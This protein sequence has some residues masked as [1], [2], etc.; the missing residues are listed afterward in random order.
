MVN[1][2]FGVFEQLLDFFIMYYESPF[3]LRHEC[4]AEERHKLLE[5]EGYIYRE[6]Y[7]E[8]VPPYQS[9]SKTL[10]EASPALGMSSDF[11]SFAA[12]GLFPAKFRLYEHQL[13]AITANQRGHNVVITAGTGSGKTECFLL[14]VISRLVEESQSWPEPSA[15]PSG[16]RWWKAGDQRVSK[17]AH[18][19]RAAAIRALI[20][21]PMNALVEDQMQR[22]RLALDSPQAR[23]WL[24]INRRG[25]RFYFGRYTGRTP[26]AGRESNSSKRR[27]LR[28]YFLKA[29]ETAQGVA[30]DS[31]RRYFFP[32]VDGGEILARWDMQ[33]VPPDILITNYS[34]LNVMLMRDIEQGMFEI[35]KQWLAEDPS[36]VFTLVVDELHMYRG[37]PGTEVALLLRN[38][39]L[40]LGLTDKPDQVRF[41]A[42]SASLEDND[43]GREYIGQFFGADSESFEIIPGSY[44]LP[45]DGPSRNFQ[46]YI[47]GFKNFRAELQANGPES[48]ARKLANALDV[49]IEGEEDVQ[50]I[51]GHV[52][53]IT[54]CVPAL[55]N[56]SIDTQ[57]HR[58]RARRFSDLAQSLFDSRPGSA[59]A[60]EA[61]AGLLMALA[62]ARVENDESG[63]LQ[64]LLPVRVH[65]FFRNVQGVW[66]CSNPNCN[67]VAAEFQ[68]EDRPVGKLYLE[69]RI[70]CECGARVLDLL[71]CQNC[72][73]VFLGGYKSQDPDNVN[74]WFLFPD[75]PNLQDLPD[76]AQLRKSAAN[77]GLYWPSLRKPA[78]REWKRSGG[79]QQ[80]DFYFSPATLDPA[81]AR[82]RVS[83]VDQTGW[84]FVVRSAKGNEQA[85]EF[86]PP[87]P[88]ICPRCGVD[89]EGN[90][91]LLVTDSDRT[92]SYIRWQ[93]TGFEK[94]NQVLADSL[95][96]QMPSEETRKLVLFSDSR[97]DA[98]KLSAGLEA[99]HYLDALRQSV[100]QVPL[101]S[102]RDV[103]TYIRFEK[104][105]T[106]NSEEQQIAEGFATSYPVDAFAIRQFVAGQANGVQEQR[107]K[108]AIARIGAP[109]SLR[110]IRDAVERQILEMGMNPAGPDPSMQRFRDTGTRRRWTS[111]YELTE[112]EPPRRKQPGELSEDARR[113]L[114]RINDALLDNLQYV[115]FA[116]MRR[117]IESLRLAICTYRRSP[118]LESLCQGLD[119]TLLSEVC[120]AT[121]R[122][123]G[124][125]FRFEGRLS[126]P[127]PPSYLRRYW[128]A[129]AQGAG[130]SSETLGEAV[131]QVLE[132]SGAMREF[133]LQTA[134]VH[135]RT[136]GELVW[137]C[138]QC[139]RIHLHPSG[140]IC[141]DSDCLSGL[142]HEGVAPDQ[143]RSQA[144]DYYEFLARAKEAGPA[145]RL[146]C[147]ELTGQ[148]NSDDALDR[149][150]LF[151]GV[152]LEGEFLP[153]DGI[154]LLSVTTTMEAGVD[155]GSLLGVMMSNMPPMR[156]NYQ[157][158]VGRAGRRGASI[159]FA[160]T[161]CRGRSHDDFYF[162]NA[163]RITS[164]PPP[165]PYLDLRREEI[166]QRVLNAEILRRAFRSYFLESGIPEEA[167]HNVH[168]Q[169]GLAEEWPN[170]EAEVSQWLAD[171]RAQI[172]GVRNALL[173]QAPP[174][175]VKQSEAL[176]GYVV[177]ELPG[178]IS[179]VVDDP[180][181][182]HIDL[183][184]RLANRGLLPMFGFP[185]RVRLLFHWR[186]SRVYPWPPERGVVD[187]DLD[188][189]IS[190]FAPGSETVK[191]KAIHTAVGVASYTPRGNILVTDPDPL[192]PP[193]AVG[194]CG[195]CQAL[196][197]S[198]VPVDPEVCPVCGDTNQYR[199]IRLSEPHGFRTDFSSGRA[200]DG[201]FE[202]TP[203]ASRARVSATVPAEDWNSIDGARIWTGTRRVYAIND[204]DGRDF[205]FYRVADG[206]GW[207]VQ[208]TFPDPARVPVLDQSIGTDTRALASITTTDVLLVGLERDRVM[209]GLDL[210]P[211]PVSGRA[212]WFSFGFLLRSAAA[213]F[214]DVDRNEF[215]VGLRTL[216]RKG[217]LEGEVFL[218]DFLENGAGYSTYIGRPEIF[219][220]F[221]RDQLDSYARFLESH[222]PSG[223]AC[224]SACYDCLKDYANMAY[225]GLL[226]WRLAVDMARLARGREIGLSDHWDGIAE[227]L[228]SRFCE[229]FGWTQTQFGPVTG[230]QLQDK[231]ILAVHPLWDTRPDYCGEELAEAIVEAKMRGFTEGGGPKQWIAVD[232]FELSRRPAWV[233]ANLWQS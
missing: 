59:A 150:R 145:F 79:G 160:L 177:G 58:L 61:T 207:V 56:A 9:S 152:A 30:G 183:S 231:A 176:A 159:S 11:P 200:F 72:G 42:A 82:L 53:E 197:T 108:A 101:T 33:E 169:F 77:Y 62:E 213:V 136:P 154:D 135:L 232:L 117:D 20:L 95:L 122:I 51:L 199:R 189:A 81:V 43:E 111:L 142:P 40:R 54:G 114:E 184:E 98:A 27:Q 172:E 12:C 3:A 15:Q 143:S 165:Q 119:P 205:E 187:R 78:D 151:Q 26:V 139:R 87:L 131:R 212:A 230:A 23:E 226:D 34:M 140:G 216:R 19:T 99:S 84:V 106:L 68:A 180:S 133:L 76:T 138:P 217:Q 107:A 47:E 4:L 104:G 16:W 196:D 210:S 141:T 93:R 173:Q 203:R 171:N 211:I 50:K 60:R 193:I 112:G 2:P 163:D 124:S 69:P 209:P 35:T 194:M 44:N 100:A 46:A 38:L 129:V 36:H 158:R 191:D 120:D 55:F 132:Q 153:V 175:L 233:E 97:Q 45:R 24:D 170:R 63:E 195:A 89:R 13:Q 7:I 103:D 222:G 29:A 206:S 85:V 164:D 147:E 130:I 80:F 166:V 49:P 5:S 22:L 92:R 144:R 123:L 10:A 67:A 214:L 37:T 228:I 6:P 148:T 121:M 21:Y 198:P 1:D 65:Y 167:G 190:Q 64:P 116:G 57:T 48:A 218:S 105:E 225:H 73:E 18:E 181:L 32:Q 224:D 66:A 179:E 110:V 39:L 128:E 221:L 168:G 118:G 52:L 126:S 127:S 156:F 149:Q 155:I 74:N 192:G 157:Q 219:T 201:R 227:N 178:L 182:V 31:L 88:I 109:M 94:I 161:V 71:Y 28:R 14:P 125:R 41:I 70:R 208:E 115:L 202:W 86:V 186:P 113:H 102:G 215:R 17:R 91:Q 137:Q 204:N 134:E 220:Y 90:R 185:T 229:E 83:P 223:Q 188:I 8:V 75:L 146:H 174:E 25:N 162:Q 96:R